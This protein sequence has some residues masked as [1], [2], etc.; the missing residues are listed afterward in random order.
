M[1][2]YS[3]T[4]SAAAYRMLADSLRLD[5]PVTFFGRSPCYAGSSGGF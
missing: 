3:G 5:H 2:L 1:S 4:G